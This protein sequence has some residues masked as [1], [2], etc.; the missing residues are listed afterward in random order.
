MLNHRRLITPTLTIILGA[1][2]LASPKASA[3]FTAHFNP[4]LDEL[5]ARS[6]ALSN[7][8]VR[9]EKRQKQVADLAIRTINLSTTSLRSDIT[10]AGT[11]A[12]TLA[13]VFKSDFTN[14]IPANE[15]PTALDS[16]L[17]GALLNLQTDVRGE[18]T[19]LSALI[20]SLPAGTAKT[21]A[22]SS[23]NKAQG[24]LALIGASTTYSTWSRLLNE[25]LRFAL[26]GQTTA[27]RAGG[28]IGG[29]LANFTV[30]VTSGQAPLLVTFANQSVN[31]TS[32]V[33]NF[34]DGNTSTDQQ[35]SHTYANAGS[36]TV[37]LTAIGLGGT[38]T[39]TRTS[40]IGVTSG[41]G[42]SEGTNSFTATVS[43][44]GVTHAFI[45]DTITP[46][47]L[48]N[49]NQLNI[50]AN[51]STGGDFMGVP[52]YP[53]NGNTGAYDLAAAGS[54]YANNS[55]TYFVTSGTL[56]IAH[57]SAANHSVDG[58]FSFVATNPLRG[59]NITVSNGTFSVTNL[60]IIP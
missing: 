37:S 12:R 5:K 9:A 50:N 40:Y 47:W 27:I 21:R 58:T 33:W 15:S 22:Q 42:G 54:Y 1:L 43:V 56:N 10:A 52:A 13:T 7:S 31:A 51:S 24:S 48:Q 38:N 57:F 29:I 36:Y 26:A 49:F 44:N 25:A 18:A 41:S 45:A 3:A 8:P 28:T 46:T 14:A 53:F 60:V 39:L 6:L 19:E 4:L 59:G 35:P 17:T 32:Y 20:A 11:V 23:L 2:L 55:G 30:N 34:G 16:L